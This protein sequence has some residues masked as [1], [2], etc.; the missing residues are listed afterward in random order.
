MEWKGDKGEL[1]NSQIAFTSVTDFCAM[2][3]VEDHNIVVVS[4]GNRLQAFDINDGSLR[5]EFSETINGQTVEPTAVCCDNTGRLFVGDFSKW[6]ILLL[7][8]ETESCFSLS[9]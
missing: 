3:Y 2:C 9:D 4:S 8:S 5:W 6:R 7:V 1:Q